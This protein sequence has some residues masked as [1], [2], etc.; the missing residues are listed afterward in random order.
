MQGCYAE[1]IP[2]LASSPSYSSGDGR[3]SGAQLPHYMGREGCKTKSRAR[4]ARSNKGH[5]S[6]MGLDND[7]R[8][9]GS[10]SRFGSPW[11]VHCLQIP[12]MQSDK[13]TCNF[14]HS[15]VVSGG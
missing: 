5:K 11:L 14:F 10:S 15:S 12:G 3:Q 4:K 7:R 6:K 9:L 2:H 8:P 13:R 1:F